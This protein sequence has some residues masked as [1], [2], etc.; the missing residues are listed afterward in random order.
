MIKIQRSHGNFEGKAQER[1]ECRVVLPQ[2]SKGST[3]VL[4]N[5]GLDGKGKVPSNISTVDTISLSATGSKNAPNAEKAFCNFCLR[6]YHNIGM[7]I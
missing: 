3:Q 4:P 2:A 5:R 6:K 1:E 7:Q